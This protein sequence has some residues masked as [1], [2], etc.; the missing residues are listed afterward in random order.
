MIFGSSW[1]TLVFTLKKNAA[2]FDW[3]VGQVIGFGE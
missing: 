2:T 1:K 3:K